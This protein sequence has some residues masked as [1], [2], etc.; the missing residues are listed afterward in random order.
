MAQVRKAEGQVQLKTHAD[1]FFNVWT[2]NTN[3]VHELCPD[4]FAKVELHE[5]SSWHS[6]GAVKTWHYMAYGK[7][8]FVKTKVAE[9]NEKNRSV[10]YDY[11]DGQILRNYYSDFKSKIEFIANGEGCFVKWSF[12]Y[13]K[14][15]EDAPNADIYI[16]FLL[17]V[18]KDMDAHLCSA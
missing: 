11:L 18:A 13:E 15:T 17:G 8:E 16:D 1:K 7:K 10:C 5:G 4:K 6:V 14:K 3:L 9:I 2:R 12:E